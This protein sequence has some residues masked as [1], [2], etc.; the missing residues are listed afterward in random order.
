M[1]LMSTAHVTRHAV[2]TGASSG[3]GAAC[4]LRLARD[5]WDLTIGARRLDRL[6]SV[7]SQSG[8]KA[9][10][11][12]VTDTASVDGF[13][14][15]VPR[16]SLLVLC[17]GGALGLDAVANADE[18]DWQEMWEVNVIGS[19]RMVQRLLPEL[20]DSGDGQI[21]FMGSI[22]GHQ[23]YPGGGGYNAAKF[24]VH[25]L[26]D[27]LR[28]ELVGQPVRVTEIAPGMVKT[29]FSEVRFR[30]DRSRADAVYAGVEALTAE[31]IADCVAWVCS[32]PSHVNIDQLV[33]QP[34]DQADAR[35]VHRRTE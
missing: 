14:S 5:S 31:D 8:A 7:A 28:L 35:T 34:R 32:R 29:D 4:A 11:L 22:A 18:R 1:Q 17:A 13:C 20:I 6:Q 24:A 9:V 26:R 33:I 30:G 19:L 21:V 23:P 12:D 27:V 2:I 3:I 10:P 25:A 15:A 16:C